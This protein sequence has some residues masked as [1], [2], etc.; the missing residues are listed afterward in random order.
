[1]ENNGNPLLAWR[2]V[3]LHESQCQYLSPLKENGV[4]RGIKRSAGSDYTMDEVASYN[5]EYDSESSMIMQGARVTADYV[6]RRHV[7]MAIKLVYQLQSN[8][9]NWTLG[10]I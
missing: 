10:R 6:T 3:I 1:M 2:R 8:E 9:E 5:E 4:N 7:N